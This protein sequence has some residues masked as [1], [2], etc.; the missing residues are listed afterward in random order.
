V[1]IVRVEDESVDNFALE[2]DDGLE[3][4]ILLDNV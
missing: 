3:F 1:L 4:E 2:T